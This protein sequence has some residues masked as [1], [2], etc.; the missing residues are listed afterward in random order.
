MSENTNK[1]N[2]LHIFPQGFDAQ[3]YATGNVRLQS[4]EAPSIEAWKYLTSLGYKPPFI[5]Q[6][7]LMRFPDPYDLQKGDNKG[8]GGWCLFNEHEGMGI[9][10]YGSWHE[11]NKETWTNISQD[12]MD[13]SQRAA[14]NDAIT[15]ARRVRDEEERRIKEQ[16]Q[17]EFLRKWEGLQDAKNS[18]EYLVKKRVLAH[19]IKQSGDCLI[20]PLCSNDKIVGLQNI[21]PD[22]TKRFEK[23]SSMGW[24]I[25]G[26]V[27]DKLFIAEGYSTGASIHEA[28][29]AAVA[30]AFNAGNLFATASALKSK[31]QDIE[32]IIAAD[33]D[34]SGPINIGLVKAKQAADAIGARIV[35][36]IC[37]GTD[38]NDMACE[39][40]DIAAH[41]AESL[42]IK[43]PKKRAADILE[44]SH[45]PHGALGL[46]Y[47]YYNA[48]S[49]YEQK[50]FAIQTAL[51]IGSVVCARNFKTDNE[52][53]ASIYL[54]NVG[55]TATGKEHCKTLINRVLRSASM[56]SHVIGDGFTSAGGVMT[57]LLRKPR[58]VSV[59]DEFGMYL[60][61]ANSKGSSNQKEAN[62]YLMQA[63]GRV[64]DVLLAKNYSAMTVKDKDINERK[65]CN[66][67][68]TLVGITTPT[69]FFDSINSKDIHSGFLNRF[70]VSVSSTQIGMRKKVEQ[71]EVPDEITNWILSVQK[72]ALKRNPIEMSADFSNPI[73]IR[74]TEPAWEVHNK[75][76]Q[77]MVNKMIRY[78]P[79]GLDG[80]F[81]RAAEMA[82]RVA[83]I[84]ALSRDP[85]TEI[86]GDTD[87]M[88]ACDY[89]ND[90][91][92]QLFDAVQ[93][94]ISENDFQKDCQDIIDYIDSLDDMKASKAMILKKFKKHSSFHLDGIL[95]TMLEAEMLFKE[96]S[97]GAG[98]PTEWYVRRE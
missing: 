53:Y 39:G 87:M 69:T 50:G 96:I 91:Y 68:L 13:S 1:T 28:T 40:K 2:L 6:G 17:A 15:A 5:Q 60:E 63:V 95:K 54:L 49:G 34:K 58:C 26:E 82:H 70:I 16:A 9:L 92:K 57:E 4:N 64:H 59:I 81:G 52:N 45:R 8:T 25:I 32:I 74:I 46:I 93:R 94:N 79:A 62:S 78:E 73:V 84:C 66:P 61:A 42:A 86:I 71:F 43:Q 41:I 35:S 67:A 27:T 56:D 19:G 72:R 44:D 90:R 55:K 48:T 80:L 83:L 65:V 3:K 23:H 85:N 10:T 37:E 77:E 12:Y 22:G 14:F 76:E 88:W 89:I 98:R 97:S 36:P 47:D 24:F 7:K 51:A 21:F 31:Y 75:F 18:H 11:G 38:F 20:V 30:I 33:D 29:G